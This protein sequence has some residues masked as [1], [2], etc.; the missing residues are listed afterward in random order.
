LNNISKKQK[1]IEIPLVFDKNTIQKLKTN[2][3]PIE[4]G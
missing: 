4:G 3:S 1:Y 2:Y